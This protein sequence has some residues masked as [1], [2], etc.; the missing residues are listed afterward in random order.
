MANDR[1][2]SRFGRNKIPVKRNVDRTVEVDTSVKIDAAH[3]NVHQGA[4][5]AAVCNLY[6]N[7]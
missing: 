5:P 3:I 4:S 7:L 6:K 2:L 1:L